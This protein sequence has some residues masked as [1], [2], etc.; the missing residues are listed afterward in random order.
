MAIQRSSKRRQ[1]IIDVFECSE[2]PLNPQEILTKAQKAIPGLGI[3][4]VYRNINL[5][6]E[7]DYLKAVHI[8]GKQTCYERTNLSHHHHFVCR[9]CDRVFDI[10]GCPGDIKKLKPDGFTLEQ[11]DITLYGLCDECAKKSN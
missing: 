9:S 4:T 1:A 2:R 11:H 3:A 6:V 7:D 10:E 8:S 5:L